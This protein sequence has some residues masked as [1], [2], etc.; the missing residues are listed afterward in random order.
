MMHK[1]SDLLFSEE[2]KVFLVSLLSNY[3]VTG[4]LR[5]LSSL[6]CLNCLY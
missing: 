6:G 2:Y 1:D 5:R 4:T 3:V